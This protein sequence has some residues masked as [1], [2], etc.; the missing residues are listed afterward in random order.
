MEAGETNSFEKGAAHR[1]AKKKRSFSV[2]FA[3]LLFISALL[4]GSISIVIQLQ[5]QKVLKENTLEVYDKISNTTLTGFFVSLACLVAAVLILSANYLGLLGS[6]DR[7]NGPVPSK[8]EGVDEKLLEIRELYDKLEQKVSRISDNNK[9]KEIRNFYEAIYRKDIGEKFESKFASTFTDLVK[10]STLATYAPQIYKERSFNTVIS[11]VER[12]IDGLQRQI[13]LQQRNANFNVFYGVAFSTIGLAFMGYIVLFLQIEGSGSMEWQ[14]FA[15]SIVPKILF[16][17]IF[18][19][20]AFFFL[21]AYRED[22]AMV[23]Y[24]RNEATNME[25]R[26]FGALSAIL[27]G[28]PESVSGSIASLLQTERNFILRKGERTII[29]E[30]RVDNPIL[31]ESL[32]EKIASKMTLPKSEKS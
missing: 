27:F 29:N 32:V 10:D 19:S 18:E 13:G 5:N 3:T 17:L 15:F 23:R 4:L 1:R 25:S 8:F 7:T 6:I 24:L 21:R 11:M 9:E 30:L 16:V 2:K 31:L 26:A 22:R 12:H 20:V 14:A 28:P